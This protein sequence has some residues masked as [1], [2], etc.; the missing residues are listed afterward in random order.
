M[1]PAARGW[2][3]EPIGGC[4]GKFVF[5]FERLVQTSTARSFRLCRRDNICPFGETVWNCEKRHQTLAEAAGTS[6]ISL[7]ALSP[8]YNLDAP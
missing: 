6:M 3:P 7:P 8:I 5:F 4:A 1:T 2:T